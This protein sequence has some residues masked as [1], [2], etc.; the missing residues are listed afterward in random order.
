MIDEPVSDYNLGVPVIITDSEYIDRE[1]KETTKSIECKESEIFILEKKL[2]TLNGIK[3]Q[4]DKKSG[5]HIS[6]T[7]TA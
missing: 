7:S 2:L 5:L 4:M 1:I 6:N 3:R